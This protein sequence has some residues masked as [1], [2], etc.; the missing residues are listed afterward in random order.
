MEA[1]ERSAGKDLD[2]YRANFRTEQERNQT[3][4]ALE[5][6]WNH[7]GKDT[8][9]IQPLVNSTKDTAGNCFDDFFQS[10]QERNHPGSSLEP[11]LSLR[12][13]VEFYK[14][15]EKTVRLHISQG[16]IA[17]R[18]EQG[19]KGLEWRIY[20]NGFP[21]SPEISLEVL[22][23]PSRVVPDWNH[24][25]TTLEEHPNQTG[26]T[27]EPDWKLAGIVDTQTTLER[28]G[29][30]DRLLSI[31]ESQNQMLKDASTKL[32]S[33]NYRIGYLEAQTQNYQ[34]EIKLL[35]DSQHKERGWWQT[36][37]MWFLNGK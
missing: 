22:D 35:T 31:I 26:T 6:G 18:K 2:D 15:S 21:P 4:T 19:S 28:S 25:G 29:S 37:C 36:F 27:L 20:P 23:E 14:I 30:M 5:P 7:P 33:A 9:V 17:A 13:A 12:E 24:S 10:E 34:E 32:E 16:K 11:V 1:A 3:G 8:S